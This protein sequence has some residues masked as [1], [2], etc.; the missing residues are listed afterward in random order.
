MLVG[1]DDGAIDH[2]PFTIRLT[3]KGF[4]DLLPDTVPVPS[5]EAGEDR[6]PRSKGFG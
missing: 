3:S 2:D 6:V 5:I 1:T 4:E